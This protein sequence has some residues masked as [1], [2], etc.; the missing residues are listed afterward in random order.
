[1][2]LTPKEKAIELIEKINNKP[3]TVAEWEM[4]SDY[5]KNDLK[6]KALIVVNEILEATKEKVYNTQIP[7]YLN[8][9]DQRKL[10]IIY[11]KY[12]LEVKQE[13]EKL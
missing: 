1:M 4:A 7:F 8:G 13:I 5:A 12:W 6:R 3:I 2:I 11:D 10:T 9:V